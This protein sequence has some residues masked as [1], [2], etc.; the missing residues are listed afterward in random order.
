[1]KA[2]PRTGAQESMLLLRFA[3]ERVARCGFKKISA[4]KVR[5]IARTMEKAAYGALLELNFDWRD[6]ALLATN[7]RNL[8]PWAM[9]VTP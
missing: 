6:A 3:C 4:S 5:I 2:E 7:V 9:G 8:C 1:M